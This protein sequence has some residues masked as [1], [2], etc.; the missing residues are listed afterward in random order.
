MPHFDVL[1]PLLGHYQ[2]FDRPLL[3]G[4]INPCHAWKWFSKGESGS[5][6]ERFWRLMVTGLVGARNRSSQPGELRNGR[7]CHPTTG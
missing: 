5:R 2:F 3:S 1:G 7:D 4:G 6:K